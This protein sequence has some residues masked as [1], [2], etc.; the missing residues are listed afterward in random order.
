MCLYLQMSWCFSRY[1]GTLLRKWAKVLKTRSVS[2]RVAA[3]LVAS[4][5]S[6]LFSSHFSKKSFLF[7]KFFEFFERNMAAVAAWISE[8]RSITTVTSGKV[9]PE[10]CLTLAKPFL[11]SFISTMTPLPIHLVKA[12]KK[13]MSFNQFGHTYFFQFPY[14]ICISLTLKKILVLFWNCHEE[15]FISMIQNSNLRQIF[16]YYFFLHLFKMLLNSKCK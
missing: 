6:G 3:R 5:F 2:C 14:L 8:M 15:S 4:V 9:S 1:P 12:H 7:S 10:Y 13:S 16:F 11:S